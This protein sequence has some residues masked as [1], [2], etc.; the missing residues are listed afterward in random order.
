MVTMM[1]NY[2]DREVHDAFLERGKGVSNGRSFL[3]WFTLAGSLLEVGHEV[4]ALRRGSGLVFDNLERQE[5]RRGSL[6]ASE[7]QS[8]KR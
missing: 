8:Q 3:D 5:E 1:Q 7:A 4:R 6:S 2:R